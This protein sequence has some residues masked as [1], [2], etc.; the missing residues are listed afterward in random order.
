LQGQQQRLGLNPHVMSDYARHADFSVQK[1][2]IGREGMPLLVID[3][4]LA[5]ADVLVEGAVQKMYSSAA[6][7]YPG[8]RAKVPLGYQQFIFDAL[9]DLIAEVFRPAR[10][11]RFTA[12]HFSLVTTP[13][14]KL[15]Y[16]Q[17]IPH[18]DSLNN[19]ELA[20]VHYLFRTD[21]GGTAFYRHRHT[22]FEYVDQS[23]F[24]EYGRQLEVER[25][26]PHSPPAD[27]IQ[28]DTP[29]YEQIGFQE[30]LFNR[31]VMYRRTT[32]HSGVIRPGFVPDPNP[33]TGRLSVTG[34]L[35]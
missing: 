7:Y 28:G 11:M 15:G 18:A 20:F 8:I 31:L 3:H 6:T 10:Q 9:G 21:L 26:G 2:S 34:F 17:R 24:P 16:L 29:L 30:G 14:E 12:C 23:R 4:C 25:N 33:R 13:R 1:L 27:Y 19:N 22:G 32:L 5:N 35:G